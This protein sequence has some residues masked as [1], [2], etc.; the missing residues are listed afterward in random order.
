M[1]YQ[2]FNYILKD[3]AM[4]E[5]LKDRVAVFVIGEN[6]WHFFPSV[7]TMNSDTATYFLSDNIES[8]SNNLQL[9]LTK[10]KARCAINKI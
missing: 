6:K 8:N 4:P 5:F 2:W 9:T 1:V 3:S 10:N 7:K